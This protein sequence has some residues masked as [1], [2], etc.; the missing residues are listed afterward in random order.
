MPNIM[1]YV[2]WRGDSLFAEVPFNEVDALIFC[3]LSYV[4]WEDFLPES[5]T[6]AL[7]SVLPDPDAQ[8]SRC[9]RCADA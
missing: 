9:L 4:R 6:A 8:R 2:A 5:G 3:T 7:E 1:D